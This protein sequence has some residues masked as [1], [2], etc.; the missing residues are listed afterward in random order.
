MM[1]PGERVYFGGK[2]PKKLPWHPLPRMEEY[3]TE[4]EVM[5]RADTY[6]RQVKIAMS[7]FAEFCHDKGI[8]I[9]DDVTRSH[10]VQYMG[11]LAAMTQ[12]DGSHYKPSYRQQQMKYL[13]AWF[14]WLETVGYIP[15][16]PW[17]NIKIGST[18]KKSNALEN[19]EIAAL[20]ESHRSQAFTISPFM[21]HRR[22]VIITLLYAWGLRVHELAALNVANMDMGLDYVNVRNKGGGT[23]VLPYGDELKIVVQRWLVQRA[24]YAKRGEDALLVDQNGNRLSIDMIRQI[25]TKLGE[26]AGVPINPHR[27][28][29]SFGTTMLDN[30]VEVERIMKMMG[31]TQRAQTLAY[32]RVNDHKVKESHDRVMNPLIKKLLGTG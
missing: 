15:A 27:L 29:D 1:Q 25:V 12:E 26:R 2:G 8:E 21:F 23:K 9:P 4:L 20:F 13:R 22:E 16:N 31:H 7:R 30:D 17:V 28:R 24:K 3:L 6:I 5:E 18:P 10:L 11:H 14:N 32:A 19:E